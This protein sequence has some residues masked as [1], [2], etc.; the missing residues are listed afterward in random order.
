MLHPVVTVCSHLGHLC[1][2][3]RNGRL[4]TGPGLPLATPTRP[5]RPRHT[6]N[7]RGLVRNRHGHR[8][9]PG[10]P[11]NILGGILQTET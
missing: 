3:S 2:L 5:P 1:R 7:T 11:A 8:V 9:L 10:L 6:P 4:L